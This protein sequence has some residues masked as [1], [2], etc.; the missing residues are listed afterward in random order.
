MWVPGSNES[1]PSR[2]DDQRRQ[3]RRRSERH[4]GHTHLVRRVRSPSGKPEHRARP[5]RDEHPDDKQQQDHKDECTRGCPVQ[6][7]PFS[8]A[9]PAAAC[10]S[11]L[12]PN[13]WIERVLK[14]QL[15]DVAMRD[16]T[17]DSLGQFMVGVHEQIVQ[18]VRDGTLSEADAAEARSL[19][20][21]ANLS[22][23]GVTVVRQAA[24]VHSSGTTRAVPRAERDG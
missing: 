8:V 16:W 4:T 24:T 6:E 11:L 15:A 20:H 10:D 1:S 17:A 7:V 9:T 5:D 21:A 3:Q 22:I 12:V 2:A 13:D 14:P 18:A 19:V 23:P